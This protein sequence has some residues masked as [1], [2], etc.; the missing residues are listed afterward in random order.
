MNENLK[1]AVIGG[2]PAGMSAAYCLTRDGINDVEVFE[3]SDSVGGL[4]K[5]INLWNQKVDIGPHRFFS[6]DKRV[7]ELWLEV[8]GRDY[9]MVNR[10]TRIYYKKKFYYYPLK[11]FN[12]LFN[13][14]IFQAVLCVLSYARQRISP[15]PEDGSFENWVTRRFGK[16]LFRIFFK[17]YT[18]KLWGIPCET[19][20]SDFAAQRI[21]KLSLYEAIKNALFPSKEQKHKTLVDQFAYPLGGTGSIY[22]RMADAVETKGGKVHLKSPVK[23]VIQKSGTATGLELEDGTVKE[24]D[25]IISTMPLTL[26]VNRLPEV[27][28]DILDRTAKLKFRNTIIVFLNI[29]AVDLFPDQWL[30]VHSPELDTGRITNFRNWIPEIYGDEKTTIL[31]MELWCYDEDPIWSESS[32]KLIEQ[33]SQEIRNTGLIGKAEIL[34]GHVY[35]IPRCYPVYDTGYKENLKPV[36]QYLESVRNLHVIGR[37]GAFKYNNQDHSILMGMLAAE[38]IAES[39]SHDLWEINTDYE[40]YQESY[41]ITETGLSKQG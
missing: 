12:A 7:N 16:R 29:D 8:A 30:Y 11:A 36:E 10:L 22:Q 26:M 4:A 38:N 9:K 41:V 21:K 31:A 27:P 37:Y 14:G 15:S 33:A 32:E 20:D 39:K 40:T 34:G 2:G 3:A 17:T 1:V 25:H 19:L 35:R 28:Q 23:R 5:T 6:S 13:L 24:F 18:E